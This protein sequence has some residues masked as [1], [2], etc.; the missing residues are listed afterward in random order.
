[1]YAICTNIVQSKAEFCSTSYRPKI[2]CRLTVYL[3][4]RAMFTVPANLNRK[5]KNKQKDI[6]I[7]AASYSTTVVSKLA[8]SGHLT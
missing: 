3:T 2:K 5:K 4:L 8:Y 6:F 7:L 1:M